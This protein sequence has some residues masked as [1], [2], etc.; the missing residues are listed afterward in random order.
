MRQRDTRVG[1]RAERV[2]HYAAIAAK[3]WIPFIFVLR[4][5]LSK[6]VFIIVKHLDI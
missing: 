2:F 3:K 5:E 1:K 4:G 6:R